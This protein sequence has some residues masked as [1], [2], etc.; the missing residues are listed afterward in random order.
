MEIPP[1]PSDEQTARAIAQGKR[2]INYRWGTAVIISS[3][4]KYVYFAWKAW[5][6]AITL[7]FVG[8]FLVGLLARLR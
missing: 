2:V 1:K 3:S 5:L 4:G 8:V 6:L 7:I